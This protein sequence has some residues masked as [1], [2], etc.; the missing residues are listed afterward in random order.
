MTVRSARDILTKID[1]CRSDKSKGFFAQPHYEPNAVLEVL[2]LVFERIQKLM[3]F[4]F[5]IE[6]YFSFTF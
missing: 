5:T 6:T 4:C 3:P 1:N 2:N